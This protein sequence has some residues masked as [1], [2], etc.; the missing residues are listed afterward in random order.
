M[1]QPN[2]A[3]EKVIRKKIK[4]IVDLE[5]DYWKTIN[6]QRTKFNLIDEQLQLDF[7]SKFPV[8]HATLIYGCI[9]G[10]VLIRHTA[11]DAPHTVKI[12]IVNSRLSIL[13]KELPVPI[14][15]SQFINFSAFAKVGVGSTLKILDSSLNGHSISNL[16]IT[17]SSYS[18]DDGQEDWEDALTDIQLAILGLNSEVNVGGHITPKEE[19]ISIIEKLK[20]L[21]TEFDTLLN[22]AEKEEELQVFLKKHPILIQ[23]YSKVYPK[24]KLGDDFITDFV[25]ASTLDQGIKYTFVEIERVSMSVFTQKGEITSDFKHADKQ[26]LD[27]DVWLEQN[28]DYLSRKLQGLETPNFLLIA[29]RS[30]SFN[31][32]NRALLRA[33][34]RRQSNM[35]F[36]TYDDV[37]Y[38]LNE[39]IENLDNEEKHHT[40][41][42]HKA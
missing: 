42:A 11:W 37:L 32:N 13:L 18:G 36:L 6:E 2:K 31:D 26:T 40:T 39:L 24:Q 15:N 23:P 41:M 19:K 4:R 35:E 30:T 21:K 9:D 16:Q 8:E 17:V 34:N 33:W 10:F 27:W 28:K 3:L 7:D 20:N 22:N 1:K 12:E 5:K 25:F 29:G 38:K 14:N